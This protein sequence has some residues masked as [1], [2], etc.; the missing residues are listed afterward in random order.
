MKKATAAK[1]TSKS[2]P[3]SSTTKSQITPKNQ[4]KQ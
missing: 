1:N 4:S 3:K 2:K